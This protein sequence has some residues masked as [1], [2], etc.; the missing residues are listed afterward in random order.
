M[1]K[2]GNIMNSQGTLT[3]RGQVFFK[4]YNGK[5]EL[6][7]TVTEI[8]NFCNGLISLLESVQ[9][10]ISEIKE[11]PTEIIQFKCKEKK[12][13]ERTRPFQSHGTIPNT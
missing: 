9:E 8:K 11:R 5:L 13:W 6:E 2:M 4:E 3:E 7:Y 12:V 10:R 1:D